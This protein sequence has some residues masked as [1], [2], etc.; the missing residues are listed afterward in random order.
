MELSN[1]NESEWL[2]IVEYSRLI[3]ASISTIRRRI[4][5]RQLNF[6]KEENKYYIEY[7]KGRA[8]REELE[9]KVRELQKKVNLQFEQICELK[10]LI[11]AYEQVNNVK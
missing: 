7:N 2:P 9:E 4:K 11:S 3:G 1:V 8:T 10:M 6:R 5:K